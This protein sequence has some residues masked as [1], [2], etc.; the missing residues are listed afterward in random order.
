MKNRRVS[1]II[2]ELSKNQLY[3]YRIVDVKIIN[4]RVYQLIEIRSQ[5]TNR[6]RRADFLQRLV[7]GTGAIRM[8]EWWSKG[9]IV[10][11]PRD[12]FQCILVLSVQKER[13]IEEYGSKEN[14]K[15]ETSKK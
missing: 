7:E 13:K 1:E 2:S 11:K 15:E 14:R 4:S 8:I 3:N 12:A 10:K 6:E 9:S 5:F